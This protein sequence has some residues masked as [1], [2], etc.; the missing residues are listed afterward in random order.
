MAEQKR[1]LIFL[2][3]Y[4]NWGG[5]QMFFLAIIRL[6]LSK[7]DVLVVLPKGSRPE[8][9]AFLDELGV[10]YEF[11]EIALDLRPAAG[12]VEK[13][14]RQW[15]RISS[16]IEVYKYLW[17][18]DLRESVLHIETAPWQSWLLLWALGLR[19]ANV[20]VTL[21]NFRPQVSRLRT[22]IWRTRLA[23]ISK[24]PTLFIFA[25]NRDTKEQLKKWFPLKFWERRIS[26]TYACIDPEQTEKV[27]ETKIDKIALRKKFGI[28]ADAFV[29]LSVGQFIDRKGRWV[30]LE[31][32]RMISEMR[33]GVAFVWLMPESIEK[34]DLD[35][36][37][38]FGLGGI[39]FPVLS[40]QVGSQRK[41][42]LEFYKIG[43]VFALASYVEGLPT[44]LLEAMALK[45]PVVAT[46]IYAVPEAVIDNKT[47]LLIPPDSADSLARAILHL[48]DDPELRNRLS[49]N[50]WKLVLE[51]FD[52]RVSAL[53]T[54]ETYDS[55][56]TN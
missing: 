41:D 28:P 15:N 2:W 5:P 6:A 25:S 30:F 42:V 3:T 17:K 53:K 39:F 38:Q 43:D 33:P 45:V 23:L 51:D 49:E 12:L 35:R 56:F 32:A 14:R 18:F 21:N 52:V 34:E 27:N 50:G 1:K 55:C 19:R 11:L 48:M 8:L 22:I 29:V 46:E 10:K 7:W 40:E 36:V 37:E 24:I 31:A 9:I 54:V 44:V 16:E 4:T 47:G 26:V 20:F 13:L